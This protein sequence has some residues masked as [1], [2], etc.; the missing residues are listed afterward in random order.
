[1]QNF[2]VTQ[3]KK[4]FSEPTEKAVKKREISISKH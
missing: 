4:C 1:M 2:K 3:V